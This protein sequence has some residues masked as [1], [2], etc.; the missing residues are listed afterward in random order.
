M[1]EISYEK[2]LRR[3]GIVFA[4][5]LWGVSIFFSVEGF[6]FDMNNKP[7][8]FYIS[9]ILSLSVTVIELL[10][11]KTSFEKD[12]MFYIVGALAYCYGVYTNIIGIMDA[13]G[14]VVGPLA[15]VLPILLGLFIEIVPEKL[16]MKSLKELEDMEKKNSSRGSI[17][18]P[19][20]IKSLN[21]PSKFVHNSEHQLSHRSGADPIESKQRYPKPPTRSL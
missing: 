2:L 6:D 8:T 5:A 4:F 16:F 10:W 14:E 20:V 17:Y 19:D 7:W 9:L 1:N 3:L 18:D 11:N 15:I 12:M 13:R 21:H